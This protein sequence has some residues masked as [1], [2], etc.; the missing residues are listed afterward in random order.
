MFIALLIVI[1]LSAS[2]VSLSQN[3]VNQQTSVV[4]TTEKP[5]IQNE[6]ELERNKRIWRESKVKNYKITLESAIADAFYTTLSPV[7]IEV[8]D[9]KAVSIRH[10][11]KDNKPISMEEAK[12]NYGLMLY[13]RRG[14]DTI[15]GM[16][17]LIKQAEEGKT[18]NGVRTSLLEVEYN[19]KF[20]Y[21][22]SIKFDRAATDSS[23]FLRVKNFETV[24]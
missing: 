8:R 5:L 9:G 15:E 18:S 13:E 14:L 20:G 22:M 23:M 21:P 2:C 17:E 4:A 16:F 12:N 10:L 19:P 1:N 24:D 11:A 6:S 7:E 3:A